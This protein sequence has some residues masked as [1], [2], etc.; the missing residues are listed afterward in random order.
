MKASVRWRHFLVSRRANLQTLAPREPP[1][2]EP[3]TAWLKQMRASNATSKTH[4]Y[5]SR[6][7]SKVFRFQLTKL[8]GLDSI[9][10]FVIP[11]DVFTGE[12]VHPDIHNTYHC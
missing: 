9:A 8:S 2:R 11:G 10:V 12:A 1:E 5:S 7:G 6:N 3:G 4:T